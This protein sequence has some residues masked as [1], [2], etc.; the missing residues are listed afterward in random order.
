M[1]KVKKM[2]S[3][4]YQPD[5]LY[6]PVGDSILET[7][8]CIHVTDDEPV[9]EYSLPARL[10]LWLFHVLLSEPGEQGLVARL[11]GLQIVLVFFFYFS[12]FYEIRVI[13]MYNT[14]QHE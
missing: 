3:V 2:R 11:C 12:I 4:Y 5:K 9:M 10:S 8:V 7:F 14:R 13:Y 6:P 1:R